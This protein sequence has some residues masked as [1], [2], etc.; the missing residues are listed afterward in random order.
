M[1]LQPSYYLAIGPVLQFANPKFP[2]ITHG[3]LAHH[4]YSSTPHSMPAG[5]DGAVVIDPG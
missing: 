1:V 2:G 3:S 4:G 5:I